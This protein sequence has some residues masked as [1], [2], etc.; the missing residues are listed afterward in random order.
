MKYLINNICSE[1]FGDKPI[2]DQK[3][4]ADIKDNLYIFK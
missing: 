1:N 2:W 4:N 3:K